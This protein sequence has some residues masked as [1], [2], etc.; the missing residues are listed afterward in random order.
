MGSRRYLAHLLDDR[1]VRL[2]HA[3][4][5]IGLDAGKELLPRHGAPHGEGVSFIQA[6]LIDLRF[7]FRGRC[8]LSEI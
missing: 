4:V 2:P 5:Q 6:D 8:D 1:D 3:A 7:D